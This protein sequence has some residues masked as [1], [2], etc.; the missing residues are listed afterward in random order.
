LR[1]ICYHR[2]GGRMKWLYVKASSIRKEGKVFSLPKLSSFLVG[3]CRFSVPK[4]P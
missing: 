3:K 1:F 2:K 4:L